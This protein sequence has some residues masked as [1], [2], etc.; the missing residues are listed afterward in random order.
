MHFSYHKDQ[1]GEA[2]KWI[3]DNLGSNH[4]IALFAPMGAGK[5][6][7]AGALLAALGSTDHSASPTFS[8]INE[9]LLPN[10]QTVYHMDWY[11]LKNEE[12]AIDAG[13]EDVL[14]SGRLCIVEWP[15]KASSLLP[16]ETLRLAI[17]I[18]GPETRLLQ[19]QDE[20]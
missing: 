15:E 14:S 13:V 1:L 8:I 5:T 3:L 10:D 7:I 17:S 18:T 2:A 16:L 12:E 4:V 6:T 9:Y 11:R 20:Q 19:L